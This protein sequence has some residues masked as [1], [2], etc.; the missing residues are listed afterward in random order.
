MGVPFTLSALGSEVFEPGHRVGNG[1]TAEAAKD[2]G[3]C[4]GTAVGTGIIDA[5]AGGIG[6]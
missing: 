4:K 5:H 2:L 1:L 6:M 3:L